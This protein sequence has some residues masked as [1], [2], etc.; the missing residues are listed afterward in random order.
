MSNSD[1]LRWVAD[2]FRREAASLPP[3]L[4]RFLNAI[5]PDI[6][7]GGAADRTRN[8]IQAERSR[9]VEISAEL[10]AHASHIDARARELETQGQ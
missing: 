9:L 10:Q 6:W 7:S 8:A 3:A 5:N 1:Q 2:A 4:D